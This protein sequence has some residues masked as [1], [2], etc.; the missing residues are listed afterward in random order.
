MFSS[1]RGARELITKPRTLAVT[2]N[3]RLNSVAL[4]VPLRSVQFSSVQFMLLLWPDC[5]SHRPERVLLWED[6]NWQWHEEYDRHYGSPSGPAVKNS[7]GYYR[8][9]T[10]ARSLCRATFARATYDESG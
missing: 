1:R 10:G 7:T 9:F 3:R 4:L 2:R 8:E 5:I 6:E